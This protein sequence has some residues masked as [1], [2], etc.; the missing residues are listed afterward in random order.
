MIGAHWFIRLLVVCFCILVVQL[1]ISV[2]KYFTLQFRSND[3]QISAKKGFFRQQILDF[4][5]FNVRSFV[6]TRSVL[7][8]RLNFAS[9][10][11]VTAGSSENS[12]EIPY[13]PYSLALEWERRVKEQDS[14]IDNRGL[15]GAGKDS[16]SFDDKVRDEEPSQL[17]HKLNPR[18]LVHASFAGGNVLFDA[19]FGLFVVGLGY[20]VYRFFYQILIRTPNIFELNENLP[21]QL[22]RGQVS[23]TLRDLPMNFRTDTTSLIEAFQQTTGLAI[24]QSL[25]GKIFFFTSL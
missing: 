4:D 6:L 7:Q 15:E 9:I 13:I 25:H 18:K 8:R 19:L 11:L 17:M 24:A 12:I 3:K 21:L 5:W 1:A 20:C 2:F 23:A 14:Q 16:T 22:F 10:S